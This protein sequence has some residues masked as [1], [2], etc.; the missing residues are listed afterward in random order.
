MEEKDSKWKV[1][2]VLLLIVTV[3]IIGL[4][5]IFYKTTDRNE[6][7]YIIEYEEKEEK[8]SYAFAI[9]K[10]NKEIL[11]LLNKDGSKEII[12]ESELL[13]KIYFYDN[14]NNKFYYVSKN[15]KIELNEY[16]IKNKEK[17]TILE[18][19]NLNFINGSK[20]YIL[21]NDMYYIDY[22]G[23]MSYLEIDSINNKIVNINDFKEIDT[24]NYK[25]IF[26]YNNLLFYKDE[27]NN[28]Y[29][30]SEG[31]R[32][33]IDYNSYSNHLKYYNKIKDDNTYNVNLFKNSES[34]NNI[35]IYNNNKLFKIINEKVY[36]DDNLL[37]DLSKNNNYYG[38][39]D[40]YQS[41]EDTNQI[42]VFTY[43]IEAGNSV[44]YVYLFDLNTNKI[45]RFSKDIPKDDDNDISYKYPEYYNNL[46]IIQYIY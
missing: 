36:Y 13:P 38:L 42:F 18:I 28:Y 34:Y 10:S 41:K 4:F 31:L 23:K 7:E 33:K 12:D 14:N 20:L 40:I 6:N 45:E 27:K 5:I 29:K 1:M 35:S 43:K 24:N 39:I 11:Y 15:D 21:S 44:G 9:S 32:E 26:N 3:I 46:E 16:D 22:N 2:I 8:D 37:T 30:I 25:E 17:K 19:T